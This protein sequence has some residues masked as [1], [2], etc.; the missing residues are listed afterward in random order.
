LTVSA[1][2]FLTSLDDDPTIGS[3]IDQTMDYEY[4]QQQMMQKTG[5][6]ST[7]R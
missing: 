6:V 3:L 4:E 5:Q 2:K 7:G 1:Q